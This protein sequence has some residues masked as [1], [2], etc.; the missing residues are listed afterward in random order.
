MNRPPVGQRLK[1]GHDGPS[2][3]TCVPRSD[4]SRPHRSADPS[5]GRHNRREAGAPRVVSHRP[6][7]SRLQTETN[8][9]W[10]P[11]AGAGSRVRERC[12]ARVPGG[13]TR[14]SRPHTATASGP[15][16]RDLRSR[17]A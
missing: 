13:H 5:A 17:K 15:F 14:V 11:R 4:C 7:R 6:H 2:G 9:L 8:C 10:A 16:A 12:A 3:G 1:R